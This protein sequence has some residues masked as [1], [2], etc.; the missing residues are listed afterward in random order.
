MKDIKFLYIII[1]ISVLSAHGDDHGK[2]RHDKGKT[3]GCSINGTVL[4]SITTQP[5]EYASI[6]V[7]DTDGSVITGGV[8]DSDGKFKVQEIKPGVYDIKIEYMGYKSIIIKD[9]TTSMGVVIN[10]KR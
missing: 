2:H 5:I 6:S 8:T 1:F 7:I 10:N 9:N 4:D 3:T